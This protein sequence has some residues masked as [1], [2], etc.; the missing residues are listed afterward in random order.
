MGEEIEAKIGGRVS[1]L[2][3]EQERKVVRDP[4]IRGICDQI[5]TSNSGGARRKFP[6]SGT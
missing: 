3:E 1:D 5:L 6:G 4:S 2:D